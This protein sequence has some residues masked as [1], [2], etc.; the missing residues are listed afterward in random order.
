MA[1]PALING[2]WVFD[3][4]ID[5]SEASVAD[6]CK[7]VW[8]QIKESLV[9]LGW[10]V[11][12]S[13]DSVSVK[14]IGDADPDLWVSWSDVISASSGPH[15]WIIIES[16]ITGEQVLFDRLVAFETRGNSRFSPNG[17]FN[18]DGTTSAA[19]TYTFSLGLMS[20]G[21]DFIDTGADG[22][23]VHVMT[24]NDGKCTRIFVHQKDGTGYGDAV[25]LLEDPVNT[26]AAW[27][28]STKKASYYTAHSTVCSATNTLKSPTVAELSTITEPPGIWYAFFPSPLSAPHATPT[29]EVFQGSPVFDNN[30]LHTGLAEGYPIGAI[31][32]YG[33]HV[34]GGGLGKFQ[35]MYWAHGAHD[36]YDTYDGTGAR[37]WIKL[38][39]LL[40]PWNGSAPVEVS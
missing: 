8:W 28:G 24:S 18:A 17:T 19:P 31:G 26:P 34:F 21:Y 16:P 39:A 30:V 22:A 32:L 7:H 33:D 14:N 40:V 27:T 37:E 15:S 25:I 36:T 12:A 11:V 35:D 20:P 3:V 23:I 29:Y 38:G 6:T 1:I 4:N 5:C 10:S 13:S 9:A 2:P